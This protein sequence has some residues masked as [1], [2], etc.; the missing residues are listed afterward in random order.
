[1]TIEF[2]VGIQVSADGGW[3][4][5]TLYECDTERADLGSSEVTQFGSF[6]DALNYMQEQVD[7]YERSL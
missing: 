1:M 3:K 5:H 7:E 2:Q 6:L 4:V